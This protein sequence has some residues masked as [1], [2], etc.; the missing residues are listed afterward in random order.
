MPKILFEKGNK[1]KPKGC[2]NKITR[3]VKEALLVAFN[4]LQQDPKA[5]LLA[6]GKANPTAFYM[7]A[8]KLIPTEVQGSMEI[9]TIKVVRV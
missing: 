4:D 8:A 7:V 3:S 9:T 5:N 6:W 2:K 1:G